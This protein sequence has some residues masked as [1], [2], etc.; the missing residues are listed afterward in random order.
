MGLA[1]DIHAAIAAGSSI[2]AAVDSAL[3]SNPSARAEG[4]KN[5]K[6]HSEPIGI[7]P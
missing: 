4:E 5:G 1:E 3:G 6:F 7:K 2:Q